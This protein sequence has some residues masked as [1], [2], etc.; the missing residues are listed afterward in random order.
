MD[1]TYHYSEHQCVSNLHAVEDA[2]YVVGGKWTLRVI[3]ALFSGHSRFNEL[4]RTVKGI[5]ARVLSN[6]LKELE[7]NGLVRREV[8]ADQIPVLVSY[9][10]TEY[11]QSLHPVVSALAQ[12]GQNHRAKIKEETYAIL[13]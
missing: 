5:S 3:I 1:K 9:V 8:A 12:W 13:A 10:T 4:Q 2:L 11:A 7:L 6:E